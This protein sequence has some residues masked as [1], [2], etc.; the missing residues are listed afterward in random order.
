MSTALFAA[1]GIALYAGHHAGDY[2]VQTDHQARHKGDAG[3]E[4]VRNCLI[5][6]ATLVLTQA[7]CLAL[8]AA[9]TGARWNF[10]AFIGA[11]AV[12]GITHYLADR[13]ERGIMFRLARL[14][15]GK[16][17]FLKLG[18]PRP[19]RVNVHEGRTAIG[20]VPLDNPSLGT[21]AWALDQSWHIFWGVFVAALVISL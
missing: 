20:G 9:A 5:H 8:M 11:V 12:S 3:A 1:A 17:D 16:A 6:S 13:R 2:W 14:L 4:G 19:H 21:G 15:P 18:V 7:A 10:W